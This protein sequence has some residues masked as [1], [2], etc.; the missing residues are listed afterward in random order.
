MVRVLLARWAGLIVLFMWVG[1]L[2]DFVT[3]CLLLAR[4]DLFVWY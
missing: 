3:A 4:L 2:D 1:I